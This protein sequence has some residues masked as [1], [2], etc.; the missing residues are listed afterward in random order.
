MQQAASL[1]ILQNQARVVPKEPLKHEGVQV[2]ELVGWRIWNVKNGYLKSYSYDTAWWP[3]EPMTGKPDDYG[4][5]GVW[6]FKSPHDAL[7]KLL[8]DGPHQFVMGSIYLW[9][10]VIEH[11]LGYR[12]EYAKVRSIDCVPG[13]DKKLL[14]LL[15]DR[16]KVSKASDLVETLINE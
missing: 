9:G 10:E 14:Q 12:A 16:Y 5:A 1:G 15:H 11:T 4:G 13:D 7:N 3:D 2:N 6:S 8:S